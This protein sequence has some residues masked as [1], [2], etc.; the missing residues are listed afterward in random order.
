ME[1][2]QPDKDDLLSNNKVIYCLVAVV[3]MLVINQ[4]QY[5]QLAGA[6]QGDGYSVAVSSLSGGAAVGNM[7]EYTILAPAHL[8][9]LNDEEPVLQG[10]KTKVIN[11]PTISPHSI[12]S[13]TGD[14]VQDTINA[15]VPTG[16]PFYG[17]EAGV[18]FDDPLTAQNIWG[19][20][21]ESI[22]LSPQ[23]EQRWN[24][25]ISVFTCDYCCGSPQNPTMINRC[26]CGHARAWRGMAKWFI[27][28]YG[29]K[30]SDAQIMGEMSRWK[31][32][33]YPGPTVKRVLQE[34]AA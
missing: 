6:L 23:E 15:L 8:V 4:W 27:K 19:N 7:G 29:D 18:S 12:P 31:A 26:G 21:E 1:N 25:I 11:F 2:L 16:T 5:A 33:W 10:Y 20:Y 9:L 24:K 3:I 17:Q 14:A 34:Q 13:K 22:Q 32:L 28:Q 30:Y